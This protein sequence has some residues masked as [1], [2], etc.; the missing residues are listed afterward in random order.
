[1]CFEG[2]VIL[3]KL[4]HVGATKTSQ[5]FEQKQLL[6]STFT[7]TAQGGDFYPTHAWLKTHS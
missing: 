3:F 2:G 5:N 1:M 4:W 7:S 6:H